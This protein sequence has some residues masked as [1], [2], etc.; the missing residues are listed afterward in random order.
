M[1]KSV[2]TVSKKTGLPPGSLVHVGKS[3]DSKTKISV[4]NFSKEY[5]EELDLQSIDEIL[6]YKKT[7]FITWVIIEGL[8]DVTLIESIGTHFSIHP[9]VLED[10][11]NTNQRPKFEEHDDYLYFV[12]KSLSSEEDVL[13]I[14]YEQVSILVLDNIVFTFKEKQDRI[15]E[16]IKVQLRNSKGRIRNQGTDY[17]AYLIL[18]NIVDLYFPLLDTLDE[19]IGTVEEKLL[20]SPTSDTLSIIQRLKRELIS[21]RRSIAPIRELINGTLRCESPLIKDS[22]RIYLRDVNDHVLRVTEAVDS[23]R[24]IVI[25]LLDIYISSVSYKLNEV[26]KLLTVFA[27]IFIPLTFITGIYGMNFEY[28]PELKWHWSYPVLWLVMIGIFIGMLFYFRRKKWI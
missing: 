16:P 20:I 9:L 6:Q 7:K 18:D 19:T 23:Y 2:N 28:M 26:M 25:G 12:I 24:D 22:V 13:S 3:P 15:F 10:I 11:L 4:V 17:L 27:T 21:M 5:F 8:L 14:I 1:P